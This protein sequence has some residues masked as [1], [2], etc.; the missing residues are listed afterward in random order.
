MEYR[1]PHGKLLRVSKDTD[2]RRLASTKALYVT[3]G[4]TTAGLECGA[5]SHCAPTNQGDDDEDETTSLVSSAADSVLVDLSLAG[6][7]GV[8]STCGGL[9]IQG[10]VPEPS[11]RHGKRPAKSG[12]A[13]R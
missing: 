5:P 1:D 6:C 3:T 9:V 11:S 13:R 8:K 4:L 12:K 2:F 10:G 7:C